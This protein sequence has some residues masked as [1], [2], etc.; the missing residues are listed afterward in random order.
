MSKRD[1]KYIGLSVFLHILFFILVSIFSGGGQGNGKKGSGGEGDKKGTGNSPF[2]D[3]DG[4]DILP[5]EI[6]EVTI[7]EDPQK[8]KGK[9]LKLK[10][11]KIP[12]KKEHSK[13]G[14][15]GVGIY[16][17]YANVDK[18]IYNGQEYLAVG[19]AQVIYG[20]P[21]YL[22]GLKAGDMIF[23]VN[24]L[25]YGPGNDIRGNEPKDLEIGIKRGNEIIFINIR[26]DWVETGGLQG[27]SAT[28]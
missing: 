11:K 3:Q 8:G 24:G 28:P 13:T 6:T 2:K 12:K 15:W 5:K 4:R 7:I 23:M 1:A 17:N 14:F 18:V 20:N 27:S 16:L 19:I 9:K 10:K 26:R 22:S 25:Q 21:A